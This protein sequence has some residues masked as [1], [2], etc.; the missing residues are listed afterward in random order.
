MAC[1]ITS[2]YVSSSQSCLRHFTPLR[3]EKHW[4]VSILYHVLMLLWERAWCSLSNVPLD[5]MSM[6]AAGRGGSDVT[7]AG[8]ALTDVS[9]LWPNVMQVYGSRS[10]NL[11]LEV[12]LGRCK[13]CVI[14]MCS[15][16]VSPNGWRLHVPTRTGRVAVEASKRWFGK[17]MAEAGAVQGAEREAAAVH[18]YAPFLIQTLSLTLLGLK[19]ANRGVQQRRSFGG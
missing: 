15:R 6:R 4:D 7:T 18:T 11:L 5:A 9:I 16:T 19:P 3:R 10:H 1:L 14:F 8:S 12:L 13:R 2:C 17:I